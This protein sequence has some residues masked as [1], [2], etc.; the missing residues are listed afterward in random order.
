MIRVEGRLTRLKPVSA[1]HCSGSDGVLT[2]EPPA[3]LIPFFVNYAPQ[4]CTQG[5]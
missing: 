5:C 2:T 4:S 1:D 3:H